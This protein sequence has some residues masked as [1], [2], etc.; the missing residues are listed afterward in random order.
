MWHDCKGESMLPLILVS[1]R[2][3]GST[4]HRQPGQISLSP[5]ACRSDHTA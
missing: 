4:K 1:V 5:M 2:C 3:G